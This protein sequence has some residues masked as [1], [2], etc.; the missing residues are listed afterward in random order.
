MAGSSK[1][2]N[3]SSVSIKL[4]EFSDYLRTYDISRRILRP[5]FR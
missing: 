1:R 2:D 3:A 5:D 4:E